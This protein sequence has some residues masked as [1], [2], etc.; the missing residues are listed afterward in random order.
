MNIY[1]DRCS[2]FKKVR[3]LTKI[4]EEE[5]KVK[6][7][8][9]PFEGANSRI[10]NHGVPTKISWAEWHSPW[11]NANFAWK[12]IKHSEKFYEIQTILGIDPQRDGDCRQLDTAYKNKASLFLTSDKGILKHKKALEPLLALTIL[13][14]DSSIDFLSL[15]ERIAL[16]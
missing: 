1:I 2:N 15:Q 7:I 5:G 4:F 10:Q 6:L 8:Q 9:F 12:D 14:P 13:D 16:L 11:K 3:A